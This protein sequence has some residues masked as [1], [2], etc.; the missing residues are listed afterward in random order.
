MHNTCLYN[1]S[2]QLKNFSCTRSSFIHYLTFWIWIL[3][4]FIPYQLIK[5]L[6]FADQH[7]VVYAPG[8]FTH[9]LD[10]GLSHEP[11][12]HILMSC[13]LLGIPLYT[14][15]LVP[16]LQYDNTVA[17]DLPSLDL[18]P[19]TVTTRQLVDTFKNDSSLENQ[20]AIL[21]HFLVHQGDLETV[22]EVIQWNVYIFKHP[23]SSLT[24]QVEESNTLSL[25]INLWRLGLLAKA[26][27]L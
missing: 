10:I 4:Y 23:T 15:H 14:S 1:S 25:K 12:C 6:L 9:L 19:L 17:V 5:Y 20:L 13:T 11:C 18:V 27:I 8:V 21:H 3:V 22:A 16:L 24:S 26:T 7:M 2:F